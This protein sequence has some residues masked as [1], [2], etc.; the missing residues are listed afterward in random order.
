MKL[1]VPMAGR[2]TRVRPHSH[3]TPKPLLSVKGRSIVERIVDT[4]ARV[5]PEVPDEGVFVLGP[6]FGQ[7]IRDRLTEICEARNMTANFAVQHEAKG[8]A[9]AVG[10]AEEYLQG[11]GVVVF[12]DTLFHI[13]DDVAIDDEADV[14]AFV[15]EVED[16]RR[17][18]IAVREG[19]QVTKLIEKPE[20][21]ISNEALI[22][23]YYVR[24]LADLHDEINYL[25]D[26]D[27]QGKG[28]EYQLTDAFDRLLQRGEVF[29]TASV[30]AWMDCGT[31]PALL[32]TTGR[33][34]DRESDDLRQGTVEDS[35][36]HEPVYVGPGATITDSVVG[37][38]VSVE[39]GA[40]IENAVVR[41]SIV[42]HEAAVENA[43]LTKSV[44]GQHAAV[45]QQKQSLNVGDH[46][47]MNVEL[48]S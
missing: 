18:G 17:F 12:A 4:F 34:L 48:R 35:V 20:D 26:N 27:L 11:D 33:V 47:Q 38:H 31:I 22:G 44:V 7:D 3:V 42:F 19:E 40:T 41:D 43:V 36:I 25:I 29:T 28:G 37:P 15:R 16:P 8:T 9:H 24:E 21:P 39:A 23:I 10:C 5:L 46:S 45:K 30:D 6:D 2:G 1:I 14:V 32:E 13:E